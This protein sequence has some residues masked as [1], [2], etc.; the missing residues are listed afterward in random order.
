MAP[1]EARLPWGVAGYGFPVDPVDWKE[2][3]RMPRRRG[4]L[5]KTARLTALAGAVGA[6]GAVAAVAFKKR[7]Q[8]VDAL[9]FGSGEPTPAPRPAP[10]PP[11][12]PSNYD[13]S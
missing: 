3:A 6:V 7:E 4:K 9:P 11:P 5:A 8:V 2:P 10:A 1:G 12:G 13:A